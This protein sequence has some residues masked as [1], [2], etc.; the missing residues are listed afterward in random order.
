MN[1][2]PEITGGDEWNDEDRQMQ[3]WL[4]ER[5]KKERAKLRAYGC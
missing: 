2:P 5:A 4:E 3:I 1:T